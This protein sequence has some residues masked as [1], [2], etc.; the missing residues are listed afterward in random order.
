[1]T[2]SR[3]RGRKGRTE[4]GEGRSGTEGKEPSLEPLHIPSWVA[5][6]LYALVTLVLFRKFVFSSDMLFGSDTLGLGYMARAFYA[7]MLAQGSFPRWNPLLL[8][9]TPFLESLAGGDALYPTT[10]L[11][12]LTET[13]RA[14]GW[15]L[16]LHVFLA[17]LFMF[18]W[19]RSLGLSRAAALLAGLAFLLAPY[20]VTLVYPG[21]DGKIFV[22]AL[23]PLLFWIAEWSLTRR[24]LLPFSVLGL[25]VALILY[26]THFQMA[27]FLF[28]AVGA[29]YIFRTVSAW[30]AAGEPSAAPEA[31]GAALRRLALFLLAAVIG[32]AAA[33]IQL[34]PAYDYI[35]DFS[36]RAATTAEAGEAR[37]AYASSWGMHPEEAVSL[38]VPEF[39]GSNTGGTEWT[40]GTYWGR[41][42][43][44]HNH[45]YAGLVVLLL[46]G[47][48]FFGAPRRGVRWFFVVVGGTALLYSLGTWTPVWRIFYEV[49]PGISLFRAPAMA[50]FLFGF[51]AAT[52]MAFG[53][54]RGIEIARDPQ[55]R[56]R[57]KGMSRYLWGAPV[58]LLFFTILAATGLLLSI[59][60][61][62]VHGEMVEQQAAA[63]ESLRPF[64]VRGFLV[65]TI[66]ALATAAVLW[67]LRSAWLA[68]AG[69]VLLLGLLVI[70][71]QFR[72][73]D[74]FVQVLDYPRWAMPDQNTRFLMERMR[75]EEPF[76][77][78]SAVLAG[79]DVTPAMHGIELAGGHH[80]ND[81]LRYRE[82]IGG[83]G[84][85]FPENLLFNPNVQAVLNVRFLLWPDHQYGPLDGIRPVSR[86]EFSDGSPYQSVYPIPTLP[87]ARLVAEAVVLPDE[88][89]LP[90]ILSE[91]F[92]PIDQVVL[93][94]APPIELPGGVAMGEVEWLERAPDHS[95][96]RVRSEGP[97]L[98]VVADNW[99]PAWR[100]RLNGEEVPVLRANYTVRAVAVPA[101]THEIEFF[102][103]SP[104]L[105]GSLVLTLLALGLLVGTTGVSL[106]REH[107]P[108]ER[109]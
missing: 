88:E 101:G 54:D 109:A 77:V 38:V 67:A 37:I 4:G 39:V 40:D 15:K 33:G 29:Y 7:D 80:P 41:N 60:T 79:Q 1:M 62:V 5:P 28:G 108:R 51:S 86:L 17:G 3:R 105:R 49:F 14:L 63:L 103:R 59:W 72:V 55:A 43:F 34:V 96:L 85:V 12:F 100:A 73:S 56:D 75:A 44:K 107:R 42:T 9:G 27:Y 6:V 84:G 64:I 19:I 69:V 48:S 20:M 81:L 71:D 10:L 45:E 90:F 30:R 35:G 11:F 76:R 31:R 2:A 61:G 46:A 83:V 92:D 50:M 24:G 94:E 25:V 8:G 74:P 68:P 65:A 95:R 78:F 47:L 16:V 23:T 93:P 97:A 32:A 91:A 58:V 82:L 13:Y 87:R 36:R 99:F 70:V 106:V 66:L 53:V 21:H 98:L 57:W 52:L 102:Y 89:A 18:G 26:T 104:L 22:T